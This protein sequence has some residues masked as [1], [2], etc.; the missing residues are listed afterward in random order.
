MGASAQGQQQNIFGQAQQGI[1]QAGQGAAQGMGFTPMAVGAPSAQTMRGYMNPYEGQVVGQ[2]LRDIERSRQMAQRQTGAQAT[3]AGAFGGSRHGVA[4]AETNRAFAEQ[5]A[6]TAAGLRQSGFQQ[7]Q[8]LAQQ[9]AL[10]NQAAQ[11]S[12]AQQRL[13]AGSQLANIAQTGFGMGRQ[14]QQD[15][16]SQGTQQQAI[17]QALIDAGKQQY[18]GYTG[19]PAQ[20][21]QYLLSAVGS[22]PTPQSETYSPGLFDYLTLG[23]RTYA[24]VVG[25]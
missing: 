24:G 14:I 4:E 1:T 10:A 21:L 8:Q 12:G 17:Q 9:A 23:A 3:A 13:A 22:A 2:S 19:A 5:A 15:M 18:A 6:Q 11:L 20:S 7:G 16:L 25:G